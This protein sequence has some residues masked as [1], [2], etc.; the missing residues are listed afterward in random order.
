MIAAADAGGGASRE[1]RVAGGALPQVWT[2]RL[3]LDGGTA[4]LADLADAWHTMN[5]T[6]VGHACRRGWWSVEQSGRDAS[7]FNTTAADGLQLVAAD[8]LAGDTAASSL[9]A[10]GVLAFY[11]VVVI[12][13]GAVRAAGRALPPRG[14]R[15][16]PTRA[17]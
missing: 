5:L 9:T 7:P 15:D 11:L 16:H 12:G 3:D 2:A 6:V 4:R 1:V 14:R 8:R 10:G 17:T 13:I